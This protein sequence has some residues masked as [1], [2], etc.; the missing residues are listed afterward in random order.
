MTWYV[1]S[2]I[3]S[4]KTINGEQNNIPVYENFVLVNGSNP[5]EALAKAIEIGKQEEI[6]N[7]EMTIGNEP[8]KMVYEG[9]RK[10]INISNPEPLKLDE[11]IPTSG[12]ELTYSQ[13]ILKN[14]KQIS[15]L[16]NG[17]EV[18]IRYIE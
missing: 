14:K 11:D 16:V 15:D 1:A 3:M 18:T 7:N 12:T 9:I 5:E 13:Y 10:L 2:I 4:I 6:C 17:S 8:A